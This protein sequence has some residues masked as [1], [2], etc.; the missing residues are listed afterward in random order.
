[1]VWRLLEL[2]CWRWPASPLIGLLRQMRPCRTKGAW[3]VTYPRKTCP[4]PQKMPSE[5]VGLQYPHRTA[6]NKKAP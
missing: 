1:M 5:G 6:D 4:A 2:N 3:K